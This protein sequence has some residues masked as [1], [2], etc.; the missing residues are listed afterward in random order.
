MKP[1]QKVRQQFFELKK[2]ARLWWFNSFIATHPYL[3]AKTVKVLHMVVV[4]KHQ[5]ATVATQYE[6]HKQS[7]NRISKQFYQ[8]LE[9][10]RFT[11]HATK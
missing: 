9:M 3:A 4:R 1:W 11:K 10:Q 8:F 7:V 6:I 2:D 5:Q